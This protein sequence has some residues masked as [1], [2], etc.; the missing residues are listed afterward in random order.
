MKDGSP[1]TY[2]ADRV[3]LSYEV[4]F[5]TPAFDLP[6]KSILFLK[7]LYETIN[8]RFPISAS[9]MQVQ[10]GNSLAD[11]KVR[12][13]LLSNSAFLEVDVQRLLFATLTG[14]RTRDDIG[15]V[16]DCIILARDAW[17]KTFP[18]VE[19]RRTSIELRLHGTLEGGRASV[20]E[21]LARVISSISPLDI[22]AD[23][24][25]TAI[26]MNYESQEEKWVA[27]VTLDESQVVSEGLFIHLRI[28]Y[29]CDG[30][31]KSFQAQETH[32][33]SLIDKLFRGLRMRAATD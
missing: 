1:S 19:F 22:G 6:S 5:G 7:A 21:I 16:K 9:S 25:S 30:E 13:F 27:S 10:G 23:Y 18:D 14:L 11:V 31:F 12:V 33:N 26:A 3:E 29:D 8:P 24:K 32:L 4:S 28:I 15:V 2:R 17:D 20:L